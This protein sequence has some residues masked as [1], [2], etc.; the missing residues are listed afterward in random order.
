MEDLKLM[1]EHSPPHVQ[2]KAA[3]G[4]RDLDVLLAV[5]AMGVTRCGATRTR[6]MLD[7]CKRRL[8]EK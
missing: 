3:G 7:E 4:V 6:E 1:R 2:V 5:R 8:A